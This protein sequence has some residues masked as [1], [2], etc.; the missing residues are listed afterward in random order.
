[1]ENLAIEKSNK[2]NFLVLHKIVNDTSFNQWEDV[3]KNCFIEILNESTK[4]E[5]FVY[6]YRVTS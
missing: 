6:A 1:M 4:Q 5:L 2:I 3:S